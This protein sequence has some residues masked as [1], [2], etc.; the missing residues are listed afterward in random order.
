MI[1][2]TTMDYKK[3]IGLGVAGNVAGHLDQAGESGG[4]QNTKDGEADAPKGIFPF[5]LPAKTDKCFGVYPYSSS[6]ISYPSKGENVQIEPELAIICSIKYENQ[7]VKSLTPI[8]FGAFNDCSIRKMA[9]DKL[10]EKKNWGPNSK[11]ISDTIIEIDEFS[12][13]GILDNYNIV[14]YLRRN[15]VLHPYG[16][17]IP[18]SDYSYIYE[19][20]LSWIVAKMNTQTDEGPL[21]CIHDLI[22]QAEY[23]DHALIGIGATNYTDF[24]KK[25]FL[26]AGDEGFVVV[27]S[28]QDYNLNQIETLL[29]SNTLT[30]KDI[31]ILHQTVR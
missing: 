30:G 17:N 9:A 6:T 15:G 26:K 21:E 22:Q 24:G 23:P 19:Q 20:L 1:K 8:S 14:A 28:K 29:K 11:G 27:Y 3:M 18:I 2:K 31:S 10:S 25:C 13:G 4:F 7:L 12:K 5:Y 16:C